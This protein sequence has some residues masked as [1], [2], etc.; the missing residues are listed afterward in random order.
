MKTN[1]LNYVLNS[2]LFINTCMNKL[3]QYAL[4]VRIIVL[5]FLK[6]AK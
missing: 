4:C 1:I 6:K 3:Q 5:L 2:Y